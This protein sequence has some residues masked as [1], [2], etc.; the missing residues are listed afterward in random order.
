MSVPPALHGSVSPS[1]RGPLVP[2]FLHPASF[3]GPAGPLLG[4][5]ARLSH[6]RVQSHLLA[7]LR[8]PSVLLAPAS[9]PGP[10]QPTHQ[11]GDPWA[12][13]PLRSEPSAG[14]PS[15]SGPPGGLFICI[16]RPD[17]PAPRRSLAGS[18]GT[19]V[20]AGPAGPLPQAPALARPHF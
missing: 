18:R 7:R 8:P 9:D 12:R 19:M 4:A 1:V 5:P 2:G 11:A 3:T 17:W 6:V 16:P 20:G 14:R 13:A 10:R 15:S